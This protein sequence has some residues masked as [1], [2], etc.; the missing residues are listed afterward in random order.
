MLSKHNIVKA[1]DG[2]LTSLYDQLTATLDEPTNFQSKLSSVV[3]YNQGAAI[4]EVVNARAVNE[5][6]KKLTMDKFPTV[7]H[8]LGRF[9]RNKKDNVPIV[10]PNQRP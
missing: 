7:S 3:T 5:T 8:K 1:R 6:Y 10:K 2:I 9:L 4:K